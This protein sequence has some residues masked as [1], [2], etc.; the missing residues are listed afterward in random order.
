M[1]RVTRTRVATL[2]LSGEPIDDL[3]DLFLDGQVNLHAQKRVTRSVVLALADPGQL[4]PFDADSPA[5]GALGFDRMLQVSHDIRIEGDWVGTDVFTGPVAFM[6]RRGGLAHVEA[7]GKER[8]AM[9]ASW[10]TLTLPRGMRK[11]D[12][13]REILAERAGETRFNIPDRP[14]KLA[15]PLSLGRQT[16]PWRMARRLAAS[17]GTQLFYNGSGECTQR[18]RPTTVGF[19]F[20]DDE[21]IKP[22][23]PRIQYSGS[24]INAVYVFGGTPAGGK[25]QVSWPAV[26]PFDHP[27]SPWSLAVNGVPSYRPRFIHDDTIRTQAEAKTRAEA[28]LFDALISHV[29]VR[30]EA[31]PVG[32]FLDPLDL[33]AVDDDS[34]GSLPFRLKQAAFPLAADAEKMTVGYT[35]DLMLD[36]SARR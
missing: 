18:D 5:G 8:L 3:T 15:E 26:A 33:C 28:E 23:G 17:M 10:R 16:W 29:L 31:Q 35:D 22:P 11:T 34:V 27:L 25:T 6:R 12:A 36:R 1:S 2:T 21:H 7:H 19:T 20:T 14:E 30:F 32:S 9:T 13:I 24:I 4:L